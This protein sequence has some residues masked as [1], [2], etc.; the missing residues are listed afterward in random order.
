MGYTWEDGNEH[1]NYHRRKTLST[2][3]ADQEAPGL[4]LVSD[5]FEVKMLMREEG[6]TFRFV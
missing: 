3:P 1:E 4:K 6:A 5:T 2:L